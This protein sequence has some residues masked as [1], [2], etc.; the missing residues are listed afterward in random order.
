MSISVLVNGS[1][2][3]ELK[4]ER[5]LRQGEPI[6]PFL[7]VI[8]AERLMREAV[9]MNLFTGF[10]VGENE[11]VVSHIHFSDDTLIIGDM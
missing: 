9:R 11:S 6:T 7:F 5:R 3:N 1:P 4:M 10:K 2:T 8:V